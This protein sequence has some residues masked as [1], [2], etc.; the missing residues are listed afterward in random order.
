MLYCLTG[1]LLAFAFFGNTDVAA[2]SPPDLSHFLSVDAPAQQAILTTDITA[3]QVYVL[4]VVERSALVVANASTAFN[5]YDNIPIFY[6]HSLHKYLP[7][8]S[9]LSVRQ[10]R[11]DGY[12]N[13][14]KDP[15][16]NLTEYCSTEFL[17]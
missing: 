15:K 7:F 3:V 14:Y 13:L 16:R 8:V 12:V 1:F 5:R 6:R 4:N 11:Y 9:V 2:N 10:S 17:E